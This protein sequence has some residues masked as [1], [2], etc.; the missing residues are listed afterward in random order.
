M[1]TWL[2]ERILY[3]DK[4]TILMGIRSSIIARYYDDSHLISY[5]ISCFEL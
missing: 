3:A 4:F 5:C 1:F 2:W